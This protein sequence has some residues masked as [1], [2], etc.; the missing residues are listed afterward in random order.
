MPISTTVSNRG[1][2]IEITPSLDRQ[3]EPLHAIF[4][5]SICIE[6]IRIQKAADRFS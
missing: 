2:Y 1:I 4:P 5:Y 6:A 3:A